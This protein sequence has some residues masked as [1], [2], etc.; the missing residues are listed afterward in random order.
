MLVLAGGSVKGAFQAGVIKALAEKGFQPDVIYGIS[1]GSLNAAFLVNALGQQ[2]LDGQIISFQQAA[3]DLWDFWETRIT[4]PACL[5]KPLSMFELGWTALTKK[6]RGL[7]STDPLRE[8]IL[9]VLSLRNLQASSVGLHIGAVNIME[10]RIHYVD[11]SNTDFMDY[12]LASS[13]VPILMPVVKIRG[14]ERRSYLDGGLRDVTPVKKALDDGGKHIVCISCHPEAI[15]G[16][17]F[18]S[19]DLLALV[20]RVMDIAVNEILNA[21][22]RETILINNALPADG[23]VVMEG[24]YRGFQRVNL[25]SIRPIQPI[26]IDIQRFTKLDIRRML[27]VGYEVGLEQIK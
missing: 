4:N 22:L 17:F 13:A 26:N 8:L 7:V 19:G 21:D 9:E 15:E 16:G 18:D 25:E 2:K 11:P 3:D 1:A 14:E 20:D 12:L 24:P 5:S 6:F 10:G 27:E 23:T